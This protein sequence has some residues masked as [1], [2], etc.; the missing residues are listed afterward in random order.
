MDGKRRRTGAICRIQM[1]PPSGAFAAD[2]SSEL[3]GF[4]DGKR[5][6]FSSVEKHTN[7]HLLQPL[8]YKLG[9]C[10]PASQWELRHNKRSSILCGVTI[11]I[12]QRAEWLLSVWHH[13]LAGSQGGFI[14]VSS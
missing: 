10:F 14:G 1:E 11:R 6:V 2:I 8:F 13:R 9:T 7:T 5:D 12:V 4:A 3:S